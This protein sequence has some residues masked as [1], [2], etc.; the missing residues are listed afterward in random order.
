[1]DEVPVD[2]IEDRIAKKI[3]KKKAKMENE[4]KKAFGIDLDDKNF[5][6]ADYDVPEP[7]PRKLNRTEP[8]IFRQIHHPMV[9]GPPMLG[10][11]PPPGMMPPPPGIFGPPPGMPHLQRPPMIPPHGYRMPPPMPGRGPPMMPPMGANPRM[12]PPPAAVQSPPNEAMAS[13]NVAGDAAPLALP[14]LNEATNEGGVSPGNG[15]V[16]QEVTEEARAAAEMDMDAEIKD[17]R[18]DHETSGFV[19]AMIDDVGADDD[20]RIKE[21]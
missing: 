16:K 13:L 14:Q 4:L 9:T 2:I 15:R 1:M 6:L 12:P 3:N 17:E 21:E 10:L 18:I 7:R 11:P 19:D 5:N 20:S 8:D